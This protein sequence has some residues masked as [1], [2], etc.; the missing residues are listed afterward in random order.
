MLQVAAAGGN[1][2][3]KSAKS[4]TTPLSD[5]K[6]VKYRGVRQRPWGKF[7]AEIRDPTKVGFV[8]LVLCNKCFF[9]VWLC[10]RF[11]FTSRLL[12]CRMIGM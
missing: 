11:L 4:S 6:V 12:G 7:A 8:E 1:G 10:Y 5:S 9:P 2:T 3:P